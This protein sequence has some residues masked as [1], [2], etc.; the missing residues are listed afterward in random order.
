[1]LLARA[2]APDPRLV[3]LDEACDGLDASAREAF[4][5]HV[6]AIARAGTTIVMATHRPEEV[7]PEIARVAVMERGRIAWRGGRE[8]IARAAAARA[9]PAGTATPAA[10]ATA[11]PSATDSTSD[12]FRLDDVTVLVGG[13]PV[14]D[15]VTWTM[16]AGES[17]AIVG[18]NG[19]GKSTLL[20]L[21]GGEE[22]P[23]SG[24]IRRLDL[25]PHAS[26]FDL[27]RR[28]AAV[29]PE[30][31]ARHRA[32]ATG[33]EVVL[34]GFAG[35]IGLA[36]PPPEGARGAA[37]AWI[38]RLGLG[39][40][41]RRRIHG[42]S[43]GELRKLLLARALAPA[44]EVLLLD[45]PLAGLD[46]PSRAW[47]VAALEAAASSG[48]ALVVVSH[49]GDEIPRAVRRLARLERGRIASQGERT[50]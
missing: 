4:L 25:G 36:E 23:A 20:R 2:L 8:G 24:T 28:I 16:R 30:L 34:S 18:P 17:W 26:A 48:T 29:G 10:T 42:L 21:L 19:A 46:A 32:D 44:P 6:S 35:T 7:V 31:Q 13:R 14:L 1:V 50:V 22:Q 11:T 27:H 5:A 47:V 41:A 33:E 37:A 12:L 49:H 40:L 9:T 15:R 39:P 45:E 38:A 3:L 43:Y